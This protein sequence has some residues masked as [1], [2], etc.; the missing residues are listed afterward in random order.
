MVEESVKVGWW[1]KVAERVG[2]YDSRLDYQS[3]RVVVFCIH[4]CVC[5]AYLFPFMCACI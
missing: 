1:V 5:C 3:S 2:L 4:V